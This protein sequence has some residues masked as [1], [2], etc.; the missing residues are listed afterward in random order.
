MSTNAGTTKPGAPI[1]FQVDMKSF[2]FETGCTFRGITISPAVDGWNFIVRATDKKGI[3]VY[4]MSSGESV[5]DTC[6][7]LMTMLQGKEAHYFWRLD[8]WA[9]D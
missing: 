1:K 2:A 3:A 9:K 6:D 4:A 5:E 8:A 7:A